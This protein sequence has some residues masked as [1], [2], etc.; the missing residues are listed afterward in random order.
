[1]QSSCWTE[2]VV[3][4][5]T[6]FPGKKAPKEKHQQRVAVCV[7]EV[8]VTGGDAVTAERE[9]ATEAEREPATEAETLEGAAA[10]VKAAAGAGGGVGATKAK[11]PSNK[12]QRVMS[13]F[14][15]AEGPPAS[16]PN[17]SKPLGLAS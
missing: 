14:F 5:V 9:P 3:P 4:L 11:Q 8:V 6:R 17:V 15:A 1:M 7:L 12:R 16:R 2:P 10:G 13:D